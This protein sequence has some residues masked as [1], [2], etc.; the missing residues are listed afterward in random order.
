MVFFVNT[1]VSAMA[2]VQI[3]NPDLSN[4]A[5]DTFISDHIYLCF[6]AASPLLAYLHVIYY[7]A[8]LA[9]EAISGI[10]C[11]ILLALFSIQRFGTSRLGMAFSPVLL[12]WF[13][14]NAAIGMYNIAW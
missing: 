9:T 8:A 6:N 4:G 11:A 7:R 2:G 12:L 10:S 3:I 5:L 14:V 1:V 13:L